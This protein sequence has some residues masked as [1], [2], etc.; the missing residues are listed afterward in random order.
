MPIPSQNNTKF[1]VKYIP[2]SIE[3]NPI[4]LHISVGDVLSVGDIKEKINEFMSQKYGNQGIDPLISTVTNREN[5]DFV[6]SEKFLETQDVM[7]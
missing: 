4:N 2:F 3:Q 7:N 6:T 1:F 5:I